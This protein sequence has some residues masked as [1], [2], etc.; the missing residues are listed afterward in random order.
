MM[1]TDNKTQAY[2][3]SPEIPQPDLSEFH[4]PPEIE[5]ASA[6]DAW[7]NGCLPSPPRLVRTSGSLCNERQ[8]LSRKFVTL[9][10]QDEDNKNHS[11]AAVVA[12]MTTIA[13]QLDR[14]DCFTEYCNVL[15][16]YFPGNVIA[17]TDVFELMMYYYK[18]HRQVCAM[19]TEAPSHILDFHTAL[20]VMMS[21]SPSLFDTIRV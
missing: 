20:A 4:E 1:S 6:G 10:H 16:E 7:Y 14:A 2:L 11:E 17:C 5:L 3:P 13:W 12:R 18:H 9:M 21:K 15:T 19:M 8:V